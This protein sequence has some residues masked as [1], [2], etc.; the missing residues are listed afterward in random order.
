MAVLEKDQTFIKG[1][2]AGLIAGVVMFIF[3][4]TFH[5]LGITKFGVCYLAGD[6]VFSYQ[7]NLPMN[8][9]SFFI[10]C[11]VGTFWGVLF[12]FAFAHIFTSAYA[13]GKILFMSFCIFFFHLGILDEPFH[14]KRE[15]H[16]ETLDL[17]IILAGYLIYGWTL[18]LGLKKQKIISVE[19]KVGK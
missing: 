17:L 5:W 14:Y 18:W 8:I 16:K 9:I 7:N 12:A 4:E 6:T 10:H 15:L 3:V 11:G 13:L 1:A 19:P 2:L